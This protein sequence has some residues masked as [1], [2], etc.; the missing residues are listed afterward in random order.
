M[1][2]KLSSRELALTINI[3]LLLTAALLVLFGVWCFTS[4]R[5]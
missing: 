2:K 1:I 4:E 3:M 5:Q